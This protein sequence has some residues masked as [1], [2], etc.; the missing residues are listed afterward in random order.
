MKN[1]LLLEMNT[2]CLTGRGESCNWIHGAFSA[3]AEPLMTVH[4]C[5]FNCFLFNFK[6]INDCSMDWSID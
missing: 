5:I 6:Q 4:T 3:I 2:F 1:E